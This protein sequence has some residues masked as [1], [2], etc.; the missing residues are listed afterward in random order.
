MR[1]LLTLEKAKRA[2]E[3]AEKKAGEIGVMVSVCVVDDHGTMV[4]MSR[5][6]GAF[7]ISPKFAYAKALTSGTLRMPT[8]AMAPYAVDGKPYHDINALFGGELT[9]IA[10]GMPIN[11]EEAVVGGIGVGGSNDPNQDEECAKAAVEAIK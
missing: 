5:M 2:I 1:I 11:E 3:A 7:T 6:D 10:G 8:S 9:T 4:A